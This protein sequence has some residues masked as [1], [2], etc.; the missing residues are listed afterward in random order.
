ML[1]NSLGFLVFFPTVL[2]VH[3]L[4]PQKIRYLWLL[5]T[6]YFFY[7]CWNPVYALLILMSTVVTYACGLL[8]ERAEAHKT[9][10]SFVVVAFLCNLGILVIFKYSGFLVENINGL[11]AAIGADGRVPTFDLLLP[12]GISFYTFQVLG[13]VMD[14]Y[15]AEVAAERNFFR[16]ALF[17]SFFPQLVA[18]PIGR[19]THLL[20]Q[21]NHPKPFDF[22]RMRKGLLLMLWGFFQKLVI[23]DRV[24]IL[25]NNVYSD[26]TNHVGLTLLVATI[27]FAIQIYCDFGGYSAIAIGAAQVL[28]FELSPN[29][30][31]PYLATSVTDFWHRWHISLSTWFRDYLYIPLGGSRCGRL[32]KYVNVTVTFLASGLWHGA[33]WNYVIWGALNGLF[34]V[35]G[36]IKRLFWQ[37]LG[38][39]KPL[40]HLF[41]ESKEKPF[42][43]RFLS[44]LIT[45]MLI[46]VTWVFFRAPSLDMALVIFRQAFAVFNPWVLIDGSLYQLG[47]AQTEFW[48]LMCSIGLL[49]V[50]DVLHEHGFSF[51][52]GLLKQ[53]IWYR[54]L[55]Y[56]CMIFAVL[57]LGVYGPEMTASAFIY[58][59]F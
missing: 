28:G 52:D 48:V 30:R 11:L 35:L 3:Y 33:S 54:W 44:N 41:P 57:L 10:K 19:S 50:T 29:F 34:Q 13:Y 53:Q 40:S 49:F 32:R 4:L 22:D 17:V 31:Q 18:G 55:V 16:Y 6:S 24:A 51:R 1:F 2:L 7:M 37:W 23:A 58:S 25:V 27:F 5:L 12:V 46:N 9:K 42:S 15:R 56:F 38:G 45:F 21:F 59:Q 39:H 26:P 36:D 8:I 14:V 47:I 20:S 43:A